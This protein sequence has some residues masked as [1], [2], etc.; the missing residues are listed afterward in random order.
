MEFA[1]VKSFRRLFKYITGA[2]EE[3]KKVEMTTPVLMEM[4]DGY[5]PFWQ[6]VDYPMS[7]LLPAEHQDNPPKPTDDK[8]KI[9][10]MPPM[11]VYVLS[12]GGWMTSLNEKRQAR[13]LSKALDDAGAKYIKGKHY[14]AGYNSPMTLFDRH[15]EV[16]YVVEGDP[17]C[18]SSGS[19]E[20]MDA[21]PVS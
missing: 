17:V 13:A 1:S 16:W 20:E 14:A 7:F 8:V 18:S 10:K 21:A 5:R 9:Q 11:K 15:N 6:S 4:E 3:G 2:N 19:S 12:Y